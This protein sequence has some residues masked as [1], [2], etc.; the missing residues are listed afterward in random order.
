MLH[1]ETK[2]RLSEKVFLD[3]IA[4]FI[5]SVVFKIFNLF[6]SFC[7]FHAEFTLKLNLLKTHLIIF[8]P[9]EQ[10]FIFMLVYF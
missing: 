10:S 6:R 8:V 5:V 4:L 3:L 7:A 2:S 1:K 9:L